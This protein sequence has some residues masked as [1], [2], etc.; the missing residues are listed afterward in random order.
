MEKKGNQVVLRHQHQLRGDTS[1]GTAK[2][3]R[4]EWATVHLQQE[5][6]T[7]PAQAM[8]TLSL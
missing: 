2:T 6:G 7:R 3:D 1:Q 5:Y 4:E 8:L